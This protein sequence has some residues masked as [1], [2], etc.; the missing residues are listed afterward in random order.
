MSD[1]KYRQSGYQDSDSAPKRTAEKRPPRENLGGP[2][3]LTMP[4]RRTVMRC[5]GCG[6][7]LPQDIDTNGTCPRCKFELHS[8]KQCVFLDTALRFE[9]SKPITVRVAKK[10]ARND[11][12]H[13]QARVTV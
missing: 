9:C 12:T 8:C 7:L 1:R 11:C 13:F 5:A 4:G 2:R 10:D 6:T 3:Q